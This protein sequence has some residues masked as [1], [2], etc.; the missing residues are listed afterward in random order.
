MK[1]TAPFGYYGIITKKSVKKVTWIITLPDFPDVTL[2]HEN[3]S[4]AL[5]GIATTL[6][7]KWIALC[8]QDADL[9]EPSPKDKIGG[10]ILFYIDIPTNIRAAY[11]ARKM[12]RDMG[13]T[14]EQMIE[15]LKIAEPYEYLRLENP[16]RS[17]ATVTS[18]LSLAQSLGKEIE[19]G[20]AEDP[21]VRYRI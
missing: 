20:T 10:E 17:N 6:I 16:T 4:I 1:Y 14:Q 5:R 18:I 15:K 3:K 8:N 2:T 19:I 7:G 21:K 12:R 9:P 11:I 13:L